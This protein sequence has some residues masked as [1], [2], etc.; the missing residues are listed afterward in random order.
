MPLEARTYVRAD[1]W[2]WL[3]GGNAGA[4]NSQR[5]ATYVYGMPTDQAQLPR[6]GSARYTLTLHGAAFDSGYLNRMNVSGTG[7]LTADFANSALTFSGGVDYGE[8]YT[9][10]SIR[11]PAT[12]SGTFTGNGTIS[13]SANAIAGNISLSGIGNYTGTFD[14]T[15]FGPS[16][17]EVGAIFTAADGSDRMIG[18]FTA[19]QDPALAAASQTLA[20]LTA[21]QSFLAFTARHVYLDRRTLAYDPATG[22]WTFDA[23]DVANGIGTI[24]HS[25]GAADID[26]A[27]SDASRTWYARSDSAGDISGYVSRPGPDNTTIALTYAGFSDLFVRNQNQ[28]PGFGARYFL[29]YGIE[30]PNSL[31]PKTGSATYTGIVR[32]AG[33][34]QSLGYS[35]DV[36]GTSGLSANF[37]SGE[38]T[39][40]LGLQT[41]EAAPRNIGTYTLPGQIA[42][43]GMYGGFYGNFFGPNAEEFGAVFRLIDD[44]VGGRTEISGVTVGKKVP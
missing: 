31:L 26:S 34:V 5:V 35:G 2:D 24:Q 32:G 18:V 1:E 29:V 10:A 44:P 6:T 30:T 41:T 14:G 3:K 38:V 42:N 12:A 22:G 11:R 21:P 4:Q 39:L 7:F 15:F 16:A 17:E 13:S 28:A 25:F 19:G 20:G 9:Q 36:T 8:D 37:R 33:S 40:T 23:T 43:N 27:M